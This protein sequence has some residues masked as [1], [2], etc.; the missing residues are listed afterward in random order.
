MTNVLAKSRKWIVSFLAVVALLFSIIGTAMICGNVPSVSAAEGEGGSWKDFKDQQTYIASAGLTTLS[1]VSGAI[2]VNQENILESENNTVRFQM[3]VDK[4]SEWSGFGFLNGLESDTGEGLTSWKNFSWAS[5]Q[6]GIDVANHVIVKDQGGQTFPSP[7]VGVNG[8]PVLS[9]YLKEVE[10]HIGTGEGGDVSY[11]KIGGSQLGLEGSGGSAIASITESDFPNGCYFIFHI[12]LDASSSR[13]IGFTEYNTPVVTSLSDEL[14]EQIPQYDPSLI[15]DG[16]QVT[17]ANLADSSSVTVELNGTAVDSQYY[18]LNADT[19]TTATLTIKKE[20]WSGVTFSAENYLSI[21]SSNGSAVVVLDISTGVAPTWAGDDFIVIDE[22]EDTSFVFNSVYDTYTAESLLVKSGIYKGGALSELTAGED[23]ILSAPEKQDDDSY[24]YTLTIKNSYLESVLGTYYGRYFLI[25]F[26][27]NSLEA[28]LYHRQA[29][30]GW[31]VRSVDLAE[32]GQLSVDDYYTSGT[33]RNMS[34]SVLSTRIYYNQGLDVTKPI[35]LEFRGIPTTTTWAM[36]QVSD[37]LKTMDY[38]SDNTA[39]EA[40]IQALFFGEG[41]T[42]I[43]KFTG[44][45]IGS[46]ESTN[47][48]YTASSMKGIVI[49]MYF[50]E[51][52]EEG[53]FKINGTS[54]GSLAVSQ[55]DF[56]DGKAYIGWFINDTVGNY[57]F[58]LNSHVNSVAISEPL[59]DS[60]Y[61][62]DLAKANDFS[63][64]LINV[65]ETGDITV[66]DNAGNTLVKDTD[67]TYDTATGT[68]T[69]KAS[70]FGRIDFAKSSVI[71]V[72]DNVNKNGTQF[73]MTYSSSNMQD[74]SVAFVSTGSIADAVFELSGVSEVSMVLDAEG[75]TLDA[76]M[77]T[78]AN[79]KL[80]IKKDAIADENGVTEFMAVSGAELYPCYVYAAAFE[81]GGAQTS[82]AGSVS[83]AD[84]TYSL[85]GDASYILMQSMS[86]DKGVTFLVDFSSIPG[87]Y[88][89][90]NGAQAGYV[91]FEFYDPYSGYTFSYSLYCN[92]D[93]DSIT[94]NYTALF[95]SYS[96][97][98][99]EG[100]AVIIP[101]TRTIN[102]SN[103]ENPSALGVHQIVFSYENGVMTITVDTARS[104]TVTDLGIFNTSASV[105]TVSVPAGTADGGMELEL[106]YYEGTEVPDGGDTEEPGTDP[107]GGE[108]KPG[109]DTDGD[110]DDGSTNTGCSGMVS[111]SG[112]VMG[113]AAAT[114]AVVAMAKRKRQ[115]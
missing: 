98:D 29:T 52:A 115:E 1:N 25:S 107:D 103:G 6:G 57:N 85:K 45:S 43:Q 83:V 69:L 106:N 97:T 2:V 16:L 61:A 63:L 21:T 65:N 113:I 78:F 68:L 32:G 46:S 13:F 104:T 24:N 64:K 71:S 110:K 36:L 102:I 114:L 111:V 30:E 7:N 22:I 20:F 8:V 105:C 60:A 35:V 37:S 10:I 38:F 33:F 99:S 93:D 109:T 74:S 15:S 101:M 59:A 39:A 76:S 66:S 14:K 92:Y 62:M 80:T 18:T 108:D 70:Y 12:N 41:R 42:D 31:V 73:S 50:G 96:M 91:T 47:A 23:Y 67:Y 100:T 58:T 27:T 40:V 87:Y 28:S 94:A 79:G 72:W 75:N 112:I 4:S 34:S 84:G 88:Q 49:E 3:I 81:N 82:G 48:N 17:V 56:E 55:A 5:N 19:E 95:E 53:Y 51:T 9:D 89:N 77:Y 54:C 11:I 44:F 90:G 26:G 86:F